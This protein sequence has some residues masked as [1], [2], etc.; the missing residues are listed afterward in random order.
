MTVSVTQEQM[1]QNM[2]HHTLTAYM[3]GYAQEKGLW[4]EN[5]MIF[6]D[7]AKG[8]YIRYLPE[9]VRLLDREGVLLADNVL[10]FALSPNAPPPIYTASAP[11]ITAVL[12]TSRLWNGATV[13][14]TAGCGSFSMN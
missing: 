1:Q 9:V 14:F 3:V 10:A 8:Q 2:F 13:R 7:A 11:K 5:K 6:L 12:K 4:I